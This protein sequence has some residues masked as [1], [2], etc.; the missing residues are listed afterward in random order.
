MCTQHTH[1]VPTVFACNS[2]DKVAELA[3]ELR[4]KPRIHVPQSLNLMGGEKVNRK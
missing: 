1:C 3:A 2:V 4:P